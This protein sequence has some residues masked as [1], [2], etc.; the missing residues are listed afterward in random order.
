MASKDQ[1][2]TLLEEEEEEEEAF[3]APSL[4]PSPLATPSPAPRPRPAGLNL[5]PLSLTPENLMSAGLPTPTLTPKTGLK[6]LALLDDTTKLTS[7]P[8]E[9]APHRRPVLALNLHMPLD[10]GLPV[11]ASSSPNS[12]VDSTSSSV[13]R[14]SSISYKSSA[15]SN[16]AGLPTPEMTPTFAERAEK[17]REN[18]YSSGST[19]NSNRSSLCSTPDNF[20][21]AEEESSTA[22]RLFRGGAARPSGHRGPTSSSSSLSTQ[23]SRESRSGLGALTASE[24]HFLFKSHNAL[25]TR[26]TDLE[27]ALSVS[28]RASV[29]NAFNNAAFEYASSSRPVSFADSDTSNGP[30]D[31]TLLLLAD[32]K[33]E[34][35]ELKRDVDGWRTRVA[36]LEKQLALVGRRVDKERMEGWVVRGELEKSQGEN[37]VLRRERDDLKE[38]KEV[39]QRKEKE[40]LEL[41][42]DMEALERECEVLRNGK[43]A[44]EGECE[45]LRA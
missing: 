4:S 42:K 28:R 27:K 5:R 14:R 10:P 6:S 36:D 24:Q 12:S 41:K 25:L 35:D 32:L 20:T 37:A 2:H 39:S 9:V 22:T 40:L 26:I 15:T 23:S 11:I 45:R 44:A 18:G 7:A 17:E 13:K 3:R 31:E 21:C 34:R 19:S 38:E 29:N 1:L 33:S 30:T 16:M 43:E 8:Q